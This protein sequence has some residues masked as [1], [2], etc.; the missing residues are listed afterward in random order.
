MFS[1]CRE[2]RRKGN[3]Y[4]LRYGFTLVQT[5]LDAVP[6]TFKKSMQFESEDRFKLCYRILL[7]PYL[8]LTVLCFVVTTVLTHK[9]WAHRMM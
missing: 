7:R 2:G 1:V 4:S 3:V 5:C 9:A 8:T 6:L